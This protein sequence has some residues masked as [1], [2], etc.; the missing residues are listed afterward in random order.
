[1]AIGPYEL[2][3]AR[4]VRA[5]QAAPLRVGAGGG[6]RPD[7]SGRPYEWARGRGSARGG[8]PMAM[9]PYWIAERACSV[10]AM[11][12]A[13]SWSEWARETNQASNWDG[14]G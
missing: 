14:G 10:A 1:M 9:G 2:V 6:G 4:G 11:V 5:Q 3:G 12:L 8:G 7:A 13:M